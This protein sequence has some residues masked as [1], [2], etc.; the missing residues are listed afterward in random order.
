[1][2]VSD[3]G[4]P[5]ECLALRRNFVSKGFSGLVMPLRQYRVWSYSCEIIYR[6]I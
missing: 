2:M 5:Q 1:M 3:I 4:A 6:L